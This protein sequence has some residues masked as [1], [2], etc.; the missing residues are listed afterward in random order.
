M[1]AR[2]DHPSLTGVIDYFTESGVAY[3][4]MQYIPGEDLED[5]LEQQPQKRMSEQEA[6]EIIHPVLDALEY[7]HT[8]N[9][10]IIHRDVKPSNIRIRPDGRI[11]LVD[12]GQAKIYAAD[13]K[14]AIGAQGLTPGFAPLEQYGGGGTDA[15]TDLYALG[16]TLYVMLSGLEEL[17]QAPA[18]MMNDTVQPLRQLN[19]NVSPQM[20]QCIMRLLQMKQEDRYPDIAALRNDLPLVQQQSSARTIQVPQPTPPKVTTPP[21]TSSQASQGAQ[22]QPAPQ[23]AKK[24]K[25]GCGAGWIIVLL[26]LLLAIGGGAAFVLIPVFSQTQPATPNVST[27]TVSQEVVTPP[28]TSA[29][30][31][32]VTPPPPTPTLTPPPPTSTAAAVSPATA[33]AEPAAAAGNPPVTDDGL[34]AFVSD[35]DGND[36]IYTMQPDGAA[37]NR[38]TRNT[39][40][41][42]DHAPAWSPDYTRLVFESDRGGNRDIY[43]MQADGTAQTNLTGNHSG[44]D[45]SPSWSPDG[46]RIAFS[47]FREGNSDIYVMESDGAEQTRLTTNEEYDVAPTWSPD[48]TRIAFVS[49][50]GGNVDIYTMNADGSNQT[51]LTNDAGFESDP[52][53]SPDGS[54]IAYS[55]A[56]SLVVIAVDGSERTELS[57][58]VASAS[59][60]SWSPDGEQLVFAASR[61]GNTDIYRVNA[62]GSGL[63]RLTEDAGRD[64]FPAW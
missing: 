56:G 53:W 46:T 6:L 62:D 25:K 18:R 57:L 38:L 63:V 15:R 16:A 30:S 54:R 21:T 12:F 55:S 7:L 13:Q 47:S 42:N 60:P 40:A 17:P 11:F 14:T 64:Y 27:I 51:Q 31:A 26:V 44:N 43:V 36:E 59:H 41:I 5:Y 50:R 10:P 4:V 58:D 37:L 9:P 35:R 22:S 3:L 19:P 52:A 33:T 8:R 28:P 2:L 32:T 49:K 29:D 48:G 20:E 1:L 61:D 24:A 45:E 39:I 34:I 23:P